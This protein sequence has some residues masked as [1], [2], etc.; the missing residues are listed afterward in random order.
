MSRDVTRQ[1][2]LVSHLQAQAVVLRSNLDGLGPVVAPVC[3]GW[4]ASLLLRLA[5]ARQILPC[6]SLLALVRTL[7]M[8]GE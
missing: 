6:S 8:R 1:E 5:N 4:S 2:E 7:I 3:R